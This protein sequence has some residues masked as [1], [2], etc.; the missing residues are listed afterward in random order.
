MK[1]FAIAA[2]FLTCIP[3]ASISAF[4]PSHKKSLTIRSALFTVADLKAAFEENQ[5]KTFL[6]DVREQ[7]EWT[8]AHLAFATPAP[9]SQLTSGTW[10]DNKTGKVYPGTF[11]I[12]R[13]TSVAIETDTRIWVQGSSKPG[14]D[15]A[16][17]T[18][19]AVELL[20]KMGYSRVSALT[21][22]FDELAAAGICEVV[23]GQIL[24]S[25]TDF[26]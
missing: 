16:S 2:L 3:Y 23:K 12:N 18:K 5:K 8:E 15:G 6:L 9:L 10:M 13:H 11:P 1:T 26:A 25:L 4:A 21:E 22:T 14:E 17:R 7:D 24:E 19:E 20:D